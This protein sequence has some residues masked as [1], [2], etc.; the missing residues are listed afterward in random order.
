MKRAIGILFL[1]GNGITAALAGESLTTTDPNKWRFNLFN[2]TPRAL[3]REMSTDRPD[4]T[5]SPYT[6]DAGH[7]QFE[8]DLVSFGIDRW[9]A[10]GERVFGVNVANVNI[11]AGLLNNLDLQLVVENYVY[12]QVRADG[13]TARKSG[14][15]DLSV[16]DNVM[17]AT[18]VVE[19]RFIEAD[20]A[21]KAA[22]GKNAAAYLAKL[23][24]LKAW[25]KREVSK[26]PRE[27]RKLVTS[28]DA[29]QYFARDFGFKIYAIEGVSTQDEP[30][31][32]K[33]RK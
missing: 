23:K 33:I 17:K 16:I 15:G 12:Q 5:E 8:A 18:A 25:A 11:K 13:V 1:L 31:S 26:L 28:H 6:V 2:P 7:F 24:E 27:K 4:K 29:F 22:Y 10:E 20:P 21:N 32:K 14:F 30:S 19:K 9:N 3:M